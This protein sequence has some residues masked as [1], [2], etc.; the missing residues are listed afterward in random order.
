MLRPKNTFNSR[1]NA[2]TAKK[3]ISTSVPTTIVIRITGSCTFVR[4]TC[5]QAPTKSRHCRW[6]YM[7]DRRC[8]T[9]FHGKVCPRFVNTS[10]CG[11]SWNIH[12][13]PPNH[14]Q[15][16][17]SP[18]RWRVTSSASWSTVDLLHNMVQPPYEVFLGPRICLEVQY[19]AVLPYN[20]VSP[21]HN[22]S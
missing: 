19:V 10:V 18:C 15:K 14:S 22:R 11:K 6:Q 8:I 16:A 7:M 12:F 4:C 3:Q 13:I 21:V 20:E 2:V 17:S 9:H 1:T 5:A